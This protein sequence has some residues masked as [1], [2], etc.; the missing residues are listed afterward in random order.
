MSQQ[1]HTLHRG[2]RR[3]F[4]GDYPGSAVHPTA[5]S[6]TTRVVANGGA[7][8]SNATVSAVS[9]FCYN[10]AGHGLL[11]LMQEVNV[12]A[13]DS[14]IAAIT[15]LIVTHGSDPWTN[16]NFVLADLTVNGMVGNGSTKYLDSGFIT[17]SSTLTLT[18]AG[19]TIYDFTGNNNGEV[20]AESF[21]S[22]AQTFQLDNYLGNAT[23][24]AFNQTAGQGLVSVGASAFT[25]YMSGNRTASNAIALYAARSNLAHAAI[26]TGTGNGGSL[27]NNSM[28]FWAGNS[29]G[30]PALWT[31]KRMSFCAIHQGLSSAQSNNFFNDIQALRTALGGGFV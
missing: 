1:I 26:A 12:V 9:T 17:S 24:C 8:P 10:L 30:S 7:L 19:L 23:F 28:F 21:V 11:A 3:Y 16:H 6:W 15:P 4:L 25:G 18:N 20:E 13:A 31:T 14:L 5:A 22:S 29:A 2:R 27:P